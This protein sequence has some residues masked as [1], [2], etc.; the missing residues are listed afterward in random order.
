MEYGRFGDCGSIDNFGNFQNPDFMQSDG[1]N[2][3][4]QSV[5]SVEPRNNGPTLKGF[6]NMIKSM[7]RRVYFG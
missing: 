5:H 2:H 6:V 4:V 1:G 3:G 7:L